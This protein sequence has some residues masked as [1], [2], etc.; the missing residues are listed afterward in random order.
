MG[1]GLV[2]EGEGEEVLVVVQQA[3]SAR[4]SE[5]GFDFET[6][7]GR[8]AEGQSERGT[9]RVAQVGAGA[10]NS[11]ITV[12]AAIAGAEGASS[13]STSVKTDKAPTLRMFAR[14]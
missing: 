9:V 6:A 11:N 4:L 7:A 8:I 2:A 13:A 12:A 3:D 5:A 1:K 10:E 14:S